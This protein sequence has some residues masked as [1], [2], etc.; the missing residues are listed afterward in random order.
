MRWNTKFLNR[1]INTSLIKEKLGKP[2]IESVDYF[3][4]EHIESQEKHYCFY[5]RS[6]L[7]HF[8]KFTNSLH[9]RT[10]NWIR[11]SAAAVGPSTLIEKSLVIL[12]ENGYHNINHA[13]SRKLPQYQTLWTLNCS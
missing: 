13:D 6:D 8:D 12:S 4:Y 10:K 7:R 9:K 11:H 2:F 1:F 3:V 5:L